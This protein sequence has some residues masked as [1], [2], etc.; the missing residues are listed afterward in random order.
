MRRSLFL[1]LLA[2]A[3][4]VTPAWADDASVPI[5]NAAYA[6][7]HVDVL[8]GDTVTWRNDSVRAHS[9]RADDGSWTS[10]RLVA[11]ATFG[12]RFEGTGTFPYY[13]ELHPTMRGDIGVHRALLDAPRDAAAPGKPYALAGRA[14]LPEGGEVSIEADGVVATTARWTSTARSRPP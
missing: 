10:P 6:A 1:S 14:A 13:C 4:P 2:F 5:Y 3:V 8:A 12:R 7:P 11:S 9:V